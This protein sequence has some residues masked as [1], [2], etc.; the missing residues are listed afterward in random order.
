MQQQSFEQLAEEAAAGLKADRELFLDVKQELQSHLEDKARYFTGQGHSQEESAE[1]ARKSFGSPLDLA[2]ELLDANRRRMK[3]RSLL[4]LTFGALVVPVA[5]VLAL[6]VGYGRLARAKAATETLYG[7]IATD[8]KLPTLPFLGAA[9]GP[10]AHVSSVVRQLQGRPGNAEN[11][12]RYWEAHRN[13]PDSHIY[14]AYY[15]L[16]LEDKDER[17]YVE[18]MRQGEKIEPQNALYN[19]LL[20]EHYLAHGVLAKA[21]RVEKAG[22]P[23]TDDM[24]DRRAFELGIAELRKAVQ[25]PY[26]RGYQ[27][28]VVRKK[29]N[30]LPHPLLTEDYIHLIAIVAAELFPDLT[31]HR[32]LARKI[33]GCARILASEGRAA[34]AEAVMDAWKP[35][36]ALFAGDSNTT[37][38]SGLSALACGTLLSKEGAEVYSM[39]GAQAKAQ[40]TSAIYERIVRVKEEWR[41]GANENKQNPKAMILSHGSRMASILSPV[42]GSIAPEQ[43]ELTPGRMHEH[44]LMEEVTLHLVLIVLALA[45]LGTLIQGAVWLH[46]ARHTDSIPLLLMPSART[47]VRSLLL[48]AVL[49]ALLYWAYSRLPMVGGREHGWASAM[50]PRFA[51][52]LVVVGLLMIWLPAHLI[53]RSIRQ[54][55]E[56]LGI[57]VPEKKE[58]SSTTRR[59]RGGIIAACIV[60]AVAVFVRGSVSLLI[61]LSGVILAVGL[62]ITAMRYARG[63]RQRYGLYYGTLARS[64]AP[65][66]AFSIILLSLT[67]QPWLLYKEANWL[68]KDTLTYGYLAQSSDKNVGCSSIETQASLRLSRLLQQALEAN[69]QA[70]K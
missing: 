57:P 28:E 5:V 12:R 8:V 38:I 25:K 9:G 39:L 3:L 17:A 26:L 48:G 20:A 62:C 69:T 16:F 67:A 30:M 27:M 63:K 64:L 54:R 55:C 56:D 49:P 31:R 68:R 32:T 1:L 43:R 14:Y 41:T 40:E 53:R 19:V 7:S 13:E 58:E 36:T 65:V 47:I 18:A 45:L 37:L 35:L 44:V 21:E 11:I 42:F 46:R 23:V 52:E 10:A 15:A 70:R 2:A 6:Y 22:E 4:R 34:D 24:L 33:P 50:W 66:Y 61:P 51:A 29:L 60:A 59:V